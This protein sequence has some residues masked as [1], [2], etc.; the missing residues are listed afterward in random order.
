MDFFEW[1]QKGKELWGGEEGEM[2]IKL[3]SKAFNM[4]ISSN[5]RCFLATLDKTSMI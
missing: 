5:N 3:D 4:N 2:T 1:E